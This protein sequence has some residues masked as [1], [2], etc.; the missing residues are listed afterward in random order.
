[1]Q[2]IRR[3]QN[4]ERKEEAIR[5]NEKDYEEKNTFLKQIDIKRKNTIRDIRRQ[6]NIRIASINAD[7]ASNQETRLRIIAKLERY[8][9]DIACVQETHDTTNKNMNLGNFDIYRS[10]SDSKTK[11]YK[12]AGV[13]IYVHKAFRENTHN[14][15]RHNDRCI[16]MTLEGD[17][18]M[19][20]MIINNTYAP[21]RGYSIETRENYWKK[22]DEIHG[23]NKKIKNAT[24]LWM[25]DNN[26]EIGRGKNDLKI[27][28]NAKTEEERQEK[29][30][31]IGKH[32]RRKNIETG[33]GMEMYLAAK[34]YDMVEMTTKK[35][36]DQCKN[37]KNKNEKCE[38]TK[39]WTHP[40]GKIERQIDY[41]LID[42]KHKN[43]IRKIDKTKDA[44]N[45]SLYQHKMIICDIRQ[46]L[47]K[48]DKS[49]HRRKEHINFDLN[50][51]RDDK[52]IKIDLSKN[53]ETNKILR[54]YDDETD[55]Q[56]RER[57]WKTTA[58]MINKELKNNYPK[59]T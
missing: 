55:N 7:N 48:E 37:C 2:K 5:K 22:I 54:K 21:H 28:K 10:P 24:K 4:R 20:P 35:R 31:I 42:K 52:K 53:E 23:K 32:T 29:I 30:E 18:F 6:A 15:I 14:V 36:C 26:G 51:M 9:I 44:S 57:I 1:M 33:N 56:R 39:T 11:T 34:K 45:T 59:K 3:G 13:A 17:D 12:Q 47:K 41:V 8:N 49:S 40:N 58:R 19:R 27:R 25:T 50:T 38:N 16:Q 43:W 46:N